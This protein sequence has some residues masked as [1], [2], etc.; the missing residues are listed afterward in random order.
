MAVSY[1]YF[2]L[3]YMSLSS[4][5]FIVLKIVQMYVPNTVN[6]Q[7]GSLLMVNHFVFWSPTRFSHVEIL[8]TYI[9]IYIPSS[10]FP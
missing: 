3:F 8:K 1:S 2:S 5:D 7:P 10:H 9:I 6:Q 4:T